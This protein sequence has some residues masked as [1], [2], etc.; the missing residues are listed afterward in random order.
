MA[1][2][3]S[4]PSADTF[5]A[6]ATNDLDAVLADPR[7]DVLDICL[8][9]MLHVP[10]ALKAV[11]AGKHVIC[12]KPI[13]GSLADIDRLRAGVAAS[14]RRLFPVF[15]YRYGPAFRRLARLQAEGLLGAPRVA[16][17][18]TRWSRDAAYCAVPCRG[19]WAHEMGGAILSH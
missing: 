12:E 4:G 14:G 19:K 17:L 2:E 3:L 11:A 15:L 10:V 13:A 5:H 16:T 18:E 1:E 7:V 9:S 6:L 8:P